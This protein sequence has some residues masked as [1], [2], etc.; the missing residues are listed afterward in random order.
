MYLGKSIQPK[1][2]LNWSVG[3]SL[4]IPKFVVYC[5]PQALRVCSHNLNKKTKNKKPSSE[6][7]RQLSIGHDLNFNF[8]FQD[9]NVWW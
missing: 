6:D 2:F 3:R 7:L 4:G 9:T 1:K 8:L 5:R